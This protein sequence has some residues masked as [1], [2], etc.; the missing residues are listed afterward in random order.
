MKKEIWN[1][2][3]ETRFSEKGFELK[4]QISQ[5]DG[6][7]DPQEYQRIFQSNAKKLNKELNALGQRIEKY[8]STGNTDDEQKLLELN[9]QYQINKNRVHKEI[10]H[11]YADLFAVIGIIR[12]FSVMMIQ[13]ID[14]MYQMKHPVFLTN[15]KRYESLQPVMIKY[16]DV[17]DEIICLTENGYTDGAMQRWRTLY[18][19]SVII[20]FILQQGEGVATAYIDNFLESIENDLS[21]YTNFAWAK[22]APC[23]KDKKQISIKIISEHLDGIDPKFLKLARG[24]YRLLSQMIH[25]SA[26]GVRIAFNTDMSECINDLKIKNADYCAGGISTAISLT[27][28]L[29]H[30]TCRAYTN[31]FQHDGLDASAFWNALWREY[32]KIFKHLFNGEEIKEY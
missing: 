31:T 18:E 7:E 23:L 5:Y 24:H 10:L 25:G 3:K 15:A 26:F 32:T 2:P 20:L 1:S 11:K 13:H 17:F 28:I 27:M 30:Q 6:D 22:A 21:Q 8:L 29:F 9:K 19:Y 14:L 12:Q 4:I 16:R